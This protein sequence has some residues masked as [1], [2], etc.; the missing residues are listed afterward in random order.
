[1]PWHVPCRNSSGSAVGGFLL[2][3]VSE[4]LGDEFGEQTP[5]AA[6]MGGTRK[7]ESLTLV[8]NNVLRNFQRYAVGLHARLARRKAGH[9]AG[10]QSSS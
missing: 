7:G 3:A 1:M 2:R 8:A 4:F 10:S 9:G 5:A 6:N